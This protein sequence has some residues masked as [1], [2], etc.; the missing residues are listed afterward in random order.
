MDMIASAH[1]DSELE[2]LQLRGVSEV[3]QPETESGI[4]MARHVLCRLGV[5][6]AEVEEIITNRRR[7]YP[8]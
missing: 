2:F 4:E 3:V 8:V 6:V 7:V 1:S 5:P